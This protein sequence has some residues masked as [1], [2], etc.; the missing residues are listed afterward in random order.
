MRVGVGGIADCRHDRARRVIA[1]IEHLVMRRAGAVDHFGGML[2][3]DRVADLVQQRAI[4]D[5]GSRPAAGHSGRVHEHVARSVEVARK[6]GV[7]K[8]VPVAERIE[9]DPARV[10]IGRSGQIDE[11]EIDISLPGR[12]LDKCDARRRCPFAKRRARLRLLGRVE[13]V[14]TADSR[15]SETG[16]RGIIGRRH[17]GKGIGDND[18]LSS[19]F[20]TVPV[21]T[22]Q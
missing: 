20:D 19:R 7:R 13:G 18:R 4:V 14:K 12:N 15:R 5:R 9:P 10:A 3:A 1:G 21:V 16:H 22:A 11:L 17:G 6:A 8:I 2:Q